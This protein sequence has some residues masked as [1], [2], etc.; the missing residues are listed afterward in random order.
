MKVS[1]CAYLPA[2]PPI[3]MERP[4]GGMPA[5]MPAIPAAG[6]DTPLRAAPQTVQPEAIPD[7][8][9]A[10]TVRAIGP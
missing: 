5:Q 7:T 1:L 4:V 8:A 10:D 2:D 6:P 9:A 3:N